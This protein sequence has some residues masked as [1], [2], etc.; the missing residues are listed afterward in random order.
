M[1]RY[2]IVIDDIWDVKRW[3][4]IKRLFDSREDCPPDLEEVS[5]QILEKC[6]GLSLAIIAISGL[7]ANTERTEHLWNQVKDSIGRALE[8]NPTIEAMMKILSLI[9]PVEKLEDNNKRKEACRVHDTVLDFIISKSI[10]ENFVTL[11]GVP[12][13]TIGTQGKVRRLSVQVS[14]QG[15][16]VIPTGLV[17]SHVRSLSVFRDSAEIP[18]LDEF[19]HLRIL[20]FEG[21]TQLQD[22]HLVNIGRLFQL[23]Y[24]N[25][26]MTSISELPEQIGHVRCLE[27]LDLRDSLVRELPAAIVNLLKLSHLLVDSE[28]KLPDGIA[29]MQALE[30]LKYVSFPEYRFD[31]MQDLGQ[32]KN[33]RKLD[34][35]LG[36]YHFYRVEDEWHKVVASSLRNL[37]TQNLRSLTIWDGRGVLQQ[38]GPLCPVPLTLQKLKIEDFSCV[39]LRQVPKWMGSLVNLQHL[40]LTV[41]EVRQEDFCILGALP[42]L[43]SLKLTAAS[44]VNS[45]KVSGEL[46]FRCLRHFCY[47]NLWGE[48]GPGLVFAA[49]SMPKLEGLELSFCVAEELSP[50]FD[51]GIENLPCL[52]RVKCEVRGHYSSVEATKAA[53]E[54]A[55]STHPN[56]P[57]V[58]IDTVGVFGQKSAKTE[59]VEY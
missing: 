8:R 14:K 56:H 35:E 25:L 41:Q 58:D 55:A 49:G 3:D 20:N 6:G 2:F 24:L 21:C 50:F 38:E 59:L 13:L 16:S 17:L 54:R 32:L 28:V 9:Q 7:L 23:R 42:A 18:S 36:T 10:E 31:L 27:L 30:V 57:S 22:H 1:C 15:N 4:V 19:R 37:G 26:R 5:V 34:L 52:I 47:Y 46:G 33:L 39:H 51:I 45:L 48:P 11:V 43:L 53:I 12:N 40:Y 44:E 29:N